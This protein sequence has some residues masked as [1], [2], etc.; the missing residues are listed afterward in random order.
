MGFRKVFA[1]SHGN[2]GPSW[3]VNG[4]GHDVSHK[5]GFGAVDAGAAVALAETWTNVDPEISDPAGHGTNPGANIPDDGEWLNITI[6]VEGTEVVP[7]VESI[8]V[9][10]DIE[11]SYR[12]DL[13]IVLTSPYGTQSV[14]AETHD[15]PGANYS[16]WR[17]N[18][19]HHWGESNEGNWTLSGRPYKNF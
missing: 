19:V 6:P 15:D 9:T 14:L 5:Y 17:F 12:G 16:F 4:A 2:G 18:T 3:G 13:E 7:F 1:N 10:L 11:H 8:D